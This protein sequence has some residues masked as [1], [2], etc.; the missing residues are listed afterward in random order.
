MKIRKSLVLEEEQWEV[1]DDLAKQTSS[2]ITKTKW[3][4]RYS[5]R[6]MVE[7]IANGDLVIIN[8]NKEVNELMQ[9]IKSL[10]EE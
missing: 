9:N 6:L 10:M 2:L 3:Q 4:G 1:L 7:K 5:W 8:R